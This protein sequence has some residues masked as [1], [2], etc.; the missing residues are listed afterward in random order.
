MDTNWPAGTDADPC[1][2]GTRQSPRTVALQMSFVSK[3]PS[4]FSPPMIL[5]RFKT[6]PWLCDCKDLRRT[7]F[8]QKVM[9]Q[10]ACSELSQMDIAD[11]PYLAELGGAGRGF[12][13]ARFGSAVPGPVK[14]RDKG[15]GAP[16]QARVMRNTIG[17]TRDKA[18]DTRIR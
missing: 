2:R 5:M 9:Q 1:V 8:Q 14:A 7:S 10:D 6:L 12:F 11:S 17:G 3:L 13:I 18:C 16:A 4:P 15:T